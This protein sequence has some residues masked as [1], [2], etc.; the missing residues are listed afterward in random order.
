[1]QATPTNEKPQGT[2][3]VKAALAEAPLSPGVYLMKDAR[4]R[5]IYVGKAKRLRNRLA[6]YA[7]E[8]KFPSFHRQKVQ[9]MVSRVSAVDFVVTATEKEALLLEDTLIKK[10]RPRYNID[11]R[12]DKNYPL[13]R[14]SLQHD[15]P[16]LSL[17]RK[18]AKDGARYF[19]PFGHAGAA[20]QTMRL[21]QRIFPLR[22]CSDHTLNNRTRPCLD[23]DTG[24]C[25]APCAG[26]I[27][28]DD[29]QGLARQMEAFF[30]GQGQEVAAEL[31]RR[32]AEASMAERYEE[33][34]AFRDRLVALERTL[35]RQRVAKAEGGDLDVWALREAEDAYVL[36][37]LQ[38][39]GGRVVASR[40]HDLKDAALA[41][42]EAMAQAL[43]SLY[44]DTNPPP[45]LVLVSHFPP[46]PSVVA[47]VL[48]ERAGRQVEIRHPQRGEKRALMDM[49]LMNAARPREP[50]GPDKEQVLARL[51]K[52]LGLAGL[53]DM[54]E[55]VDISHLGGSL[56]VASLV[57]MQK[58]EPFKAGYRRYKIV[59]T[60]GT[61]DDY[62]AMAEVVGR[63][64]KGDRPPPDLLLL[65]G[66]KG[67][68][69]V[70]MD[71]LQNLSCEMRPAVAA[72][73]KGK[74]GL[75]DRLYLPGR[76]NPV[77]FK[78]GDPALLL[79]M[80]LRDE[81]HRF[82]ITYHRLLRKKALTRSILEEIPGI[83]PKRRK[84]LFKAFGSLAALKKAG[85]GEIAGRAGLD[86]DMAQRVYGFLAAL[87]SPH[88]PE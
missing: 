37:L 7:R 85:A 57:A 35:E 12:D 38:V 50:R 75:P 1:M 19:G 20:R 63:R 5:V 78:Q 21:L 46:G 26:R 74:R 23:F 45:P 42:D 10:H 44:E 68:L 32:M 81:A 43:V 31:K 67:Q 65:D 83:G 51:Q 82:A 34:A 77:N 69:G 8:E 71:V 60:S 9:A 16:R 47:E 76:K 62:A 64:L 40:V 41:P 86:G 39:R 17:V 25:V 48:A 87:D 4:G 30:K 73:A 80:R 72:L 53:P 36:A 2:E 27:S 84:D 3:A 22:R 61:P 28:Q 29:Y 33:A 6:S 18:P 15:F 49:A 70:A 66:G 52:K 55:C 59:S 79:L 11:L 14:L 88:P 54:M 56:T 58:G 13:F 24:R